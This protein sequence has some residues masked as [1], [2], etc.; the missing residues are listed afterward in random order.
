MLLTAGSN[1]RQQGKDCAYVIYADRIWNVTD[2]LSLIRSG[3]NLLDWPVL[4]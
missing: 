1:H 4:L 2:R 3:E